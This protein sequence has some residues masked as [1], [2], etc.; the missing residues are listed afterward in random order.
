MT[1]ENQGTPPKNLSTHDPNNGGIVSMTIPTLADIVLPIFGGCCC[2]MNCSE[3]QK[4]VEKSRTDENGDP[5]MGG[6]PCCPETNPPIQS[7]G[8]PTPAGQR[9]KTGICQEIE[10]QLNLHGNIYLNFAFAFEPILDIPPGL[11]S[12]PGIGFPL[13]GIP[14]LNLPG[15]PLPPFPGINLPGF[16]LPSFD[17]GLDLGLS[18]NLPSLPGLPFFTMTLFPISLGLDLFKLKLP[19]IPDFDPCEIAKFIGQL[20]PDTDCDLKGININI[21]LCYLTILLFFLMLIQPILAVLLGMKEKGM[22]SVDESEPD[23]DDPA[24][25]VPT[26]PVV[27]SPPRISI[28]NTSDPNIENNA[29]MFA[30][31]TPSSPV[32]VDFMISAFELKN[33]FTTD[34]GVVPFPDHAA[35]RP[36]A[37]AQPETEITG[38]EHF[39]Y[40]WS[41]HYP[42]S[43]ALSSRAN[44]SPSP[45]SYATAFNSFKNSL[46]NLPP[47]NQRKINIGG[48]ANRGTG[49]APATY[50]DRTLTHNF[51]LPGLYEIYCDVSLG[52]KTVTMLTFVQIG[53]PKLATE[54]PPILQAMPRETM[55]A[56]T[57]GTPIQKTATSAQ[58]IEQP[59]ATAAVA[60]TQSEPQVPPAAPAK[61]PKKGI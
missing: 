60:K 41:I 25:V 28:V 16:P 44:A 32:K 3:E 31:A 11:P 48:R 24:S 20:P 40:K 21:P 42:P 50:T 58:P 39:T 38:E 8:D 12:I 14:S 1:E 22:V 46:I 37:R 13:F 43:I 5:S 59:A 29:M 9:K 10:L 7:K 47:L 23:D 61:T 6:G 51:E 33:A 55:T 52:G 27:N 45:D 36:A 4:N 15:I 57:A 26:P 54:L 34:A 17:L 19:N 56:A 2:V 49:N 30:S 35:A 18:L 53:K